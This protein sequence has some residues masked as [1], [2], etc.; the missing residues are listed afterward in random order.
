[1]ENRHT[2]KRFTI[3]ITALL[4]GC[5]L[6]GCVT[7]I[8]EENAGDKY[9]KFVSGTL[10]L[11]TDLGR[12]GNNIW[13]ADGMYQAVAKRDWAGLAKITIEAGSGDDIGY[14]Y[15]GVAAEGLG[16][17]DAAREYYRLSI[18]ASVT[19]KFPTQCTYANGANYLGQQCHGLV[20]PRD[21][22]SRLAALR[23]TR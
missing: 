22:Q 20:L 4:L 10:R 23:Y 7:P 13:F 11:R 16:H 2:K 5:L 19:Q 14:F 21:A 8:T 6:G 12:V 1:M 3:A 9:D 17:I 18:Q 15:L